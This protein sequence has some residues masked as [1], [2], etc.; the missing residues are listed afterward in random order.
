MLLGAVGFRKAKVA[1]TILALILISIVFGLLTGFFF[2][3]DCIEDMS[4]KLYN[5]GPSY[6]VSILNWFYSIM[7]VLQVAICAGGTFYRLK[8]IK[9]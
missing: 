9:L 3:A 5:A 4:E 8:T 7:L 1:K 2:D 6:I